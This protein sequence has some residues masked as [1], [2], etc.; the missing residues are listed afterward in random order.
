MNAIVNGVFIGCECGGRANGGVLGCA[1]GGANGSAAPPPEPVNW[2]VTGGVKVGFGVNGSAAPPVQRGVIGWEGLSG[3]ME[4]C[5]CV[6][7]VRM[8]V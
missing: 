6:M 8:G 5:T 3:G 7:G 4:A 1:D 2:D